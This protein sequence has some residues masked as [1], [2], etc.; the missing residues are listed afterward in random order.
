MS[1]KRTC[2]A[3]HILSAVWLLSNPASA[4]PGGRSSLA[5]DITIAVQGRFSQS[6]LLLLPS[7]FDPKRTYSLIVGLHGHGGDGAGLAA[8]FS[9]F[10]DQPVLL[11]FPQGE[12]RRERGGWSWDVMTE[13]RKI[14]EKVDEAAVARLVEAIQAVKAS[15]PVR[16]IIVFGFSQG[17]LM[18][19]LVGLSH[20]SLIAG[21]AAVSGDL[22]EIDKPGSL[23]R[24]ADIERAK[25]VRIFAGRG[26]SDPLVSREIYTEQVEYLKGRGLTVSGCEFQGGHAL[27]GM[28]LARMWKWLKKGLI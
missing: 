4:Q 7:G 26:V 19:Y 3:V 6:V 21:I 28:L 27:T 10:R 12:Y 14:R 8:A 25:N 1:R 2:L 18:A 13:D 11:A 23:L 22:P 17:A 5:R 9:G 20:P 15:Y 16:K 24:A